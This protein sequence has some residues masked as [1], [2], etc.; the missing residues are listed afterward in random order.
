MEDDRALPVPREE[1]GG[2]SKANA[3]RVEHKQDLLAH[4]EVL[5]QRKM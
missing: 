4:F 5:S 3:R 1:S 2:S